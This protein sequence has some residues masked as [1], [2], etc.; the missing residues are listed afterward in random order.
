TPRGGRR[1]VPTRRPS[2]GCRA[3]PSRTMRTAIAEPPSPDYSPIRILTLAPG[4]RAVELGCRLLIEAQLDAAQQLLELAHRA[5]AGDG[6]G[7]AGPVCEP[8]QRDLRGGG[9]DLARGF[10]DS[11]QDG[12]PT[13]V[14]VSLLHADRPRCG[15]QRGAGT[16]LTGEEAAA[17]RGVGNHA[18]ALLATQW[19][20]LALV[21]VAEDEVVL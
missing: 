19:L 2:S 13:V 15:G 11:G 17:Q 8:R 21:L 14:H 10:V 12:E 6:R 18:H 16:V 3:S 4:A 1:T 7:D 9:S 20:E 5:G